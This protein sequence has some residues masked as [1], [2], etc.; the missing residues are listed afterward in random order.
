MKKPYSGLAKFYDMFYAHKY[1]TSE[2]EV[3][4]IESCFSKF[5]KR[6][7]AEILDVACGTGRHAIKLAQNYKVV[8]LDY[9]KGML[10]LAK[11]KSGSNRVKWIRGDMRKLRFTNKFDAVLCMFTAF[12]YMR[13]NED[14]LLALKGFYKAARNGGVVV[15][16]CN[17]FLEN[18]RLGIR[19]S[20]SDRVGKFR[21]VSKYRI[22]SN[23]ALWYHQDFIYDGGK[24]I[25][26]E[27]H[28]LRIFTRP[29][30][31]YLLECAGFKDIHCFNSFSFKKNGK[32]TR[33]IF[34]AKK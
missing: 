1:K 5:S 11:Q 20:I 25:N 12:N 14:A 19:W 8:G 4:F 7:V 16:D 21:R 34:V 28:L 26:K 24:L 32:G 3:Q 18:F 27:L 17:N 6:K 13:T 15:I 31:E 30:L 2:K 23:S 10:D 33:L 22:D 9:S 29:E